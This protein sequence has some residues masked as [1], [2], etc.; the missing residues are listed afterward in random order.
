M[1]KIIIPKE[2]Y[3][4]HNQNDSI[5]ERIEKLKEMEKQQ[6]GAYYHNGLYIPYTYIIE[7]DNI[8]YYI[9]IELANGSNK[10]SLM[11]LCR[12]FNNLDDKNID[13]FYNVVLL[14]KF[15]Y[16]LMQYGATNFIYVFNKK[17]EHLFDKYDDLK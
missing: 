10:F 16:K 9:N 4:K 14:K 12:Y 1:S 8:T 2:I 7:I 17:Y 11:E 5:K 15:S 13:D 3:E 6:S